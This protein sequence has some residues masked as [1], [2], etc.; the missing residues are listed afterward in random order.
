MLDS[1]RAVKPCIVPVRLRRSSTV[2]EWIEPAG[3][4]LG[5]HAASFESV[6]TPPFSI[7][8]L[9]EALAA[10]DADD[11][12][13]DRHGAFPVAGLA[14]LREAGLLRATLPAGEGGA[15]L[16]EPGRTETLRDVLSAV[17]RH[18]LVL[19]R[20]YEGHVNAHGLVLRYGG[21]AARARLG[22]DARAGRLSGVWNT[23]PAEESGEGLVLHGRM[24]AGCKTYASGAGFVTRPLVTARLPDGRRQM[25]IAD[26]DDGGRADLSGWRAHGMR[27][28]ASG[29]LDFDGYVVGDANLIG[30][31]DDYQR[32]PYF[33]C[34]AWRFLAVQSGGLQGVFE[35]HRAH[36][37]LTG[38]GQ[39]PHQLARLG[40][41]AAA[42][43]TA[44]AAVRRAAEAARDAEA[45]PEAA[46]AAVGLARGIVERAGLEGLEL[47]QRSV[48]LSGYLEPHP[49]ERRMRDLAT[50]LRQPGPDYAL[51]GAARFLLDS[52]EPL[53]RVWPEAG[54]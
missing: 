17:G 34:G 36:L 18:S 6:V 27:A 22:E 35:A 51:V 8:R 54:P 24:L 13:L 20:L 47:A 21:E 5:R 37:R 23:E 14:V 31:P 3:S 25:V 28:S 16:C 29:R 41:A 48:G 26:L 44:R 32:Q 42:V 38:R 15:G 46:I 49:L 4:L 40:Q 45:R 9:E 39:D 52:P 1:R 50:Y 19:G 7:E 12:G 11:P 10:D 30:E 43:E 2:P 33:F 53:N